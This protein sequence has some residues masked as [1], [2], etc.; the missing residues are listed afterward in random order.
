MKKTILI[1]IITFILSTILAISCTI[2]P[3]EATT[4]ANV[5]S[6]TTGKP[7][8]ITLE[9]AQVLIDSAVQVA[10][11]K[12]PLVIDS[13][14]NF[15]KGINSDF[16]SDLGNMEFRN[17]YYSRRETNIDESSNIRTLEEMSDRDYALE[18]ASATGSNGSFFWMDG[19]PDQSNITLT[20]E[21]PQN[22]TKFWLNSNWLLINQQ[23][24]IYCLADLKTFDTNDE[25]KAYFSSVGWNKS[26]TLYRTSDGTIKVT[27]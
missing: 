26:N 11:S 22:Y 15:T 23:K 7:N 16:G 20:A 5:Q 17:I 10:L 8:Y 27:Y 13:N 12:D 19:N 9:E 18:V 25:A 6:K 24:G 2:D 3:I 14:V 1:L 21:A 4:S